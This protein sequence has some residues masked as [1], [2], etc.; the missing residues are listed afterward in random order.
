[1]DD[2][3]DGDARRTLAARVWLFRP[4]GSACAR[5]G[6]RIVRPQLVQLVSL[7]SHRQVLPLSWHASGYGGPGGRVQLRQQSGTD[8]RGTRSRLRLRRDLQS[9][10][11]AYPCARV[12]LGPAGR[13][14]QAIA[15]C[16]SWAGRVDRGGAFVDRNWLPCCAG[17]FADF[18]V[19]RG[20]GCGTGRILLDRDNPMTTVL[21]EQLAAYAGVPVIV[22]GAAGFIGRWVSRLLSQSGA[23]LHLVVRHPGAARRT[24]ARCGVQGEVIELDLQK[25]NRLAILLADIRPA[26]LFNLAG[27]GVD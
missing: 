20:D 1:P 21:A 14:S 16:F 5:S 4:N 9:P 18:G 25:P 24:L 12:C 23:R 3:W 26:I 27:Y 19:D 2:T 13:L 6:R 15:G 8:P 17:P 10:R 7:A 22:L 11:S